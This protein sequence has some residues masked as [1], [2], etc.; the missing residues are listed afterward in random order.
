MEFEGLSMVSNYASLYNSS[1]CSW[2]SAQ[3]LAQ[4]Q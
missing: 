2:D 4:I 1:S 3:D